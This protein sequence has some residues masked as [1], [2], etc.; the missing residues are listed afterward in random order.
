[1]VKIEGNRAYFDEMTIEYVDADIM[2]IYL[3]LGDKEDIKETLFQYTR[4]TN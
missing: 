2:N 4:I 1:M 3:V